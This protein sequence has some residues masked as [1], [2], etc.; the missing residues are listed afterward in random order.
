M[1][2]KVKV[3]VEVSLQPGDVQAVM[4]WVEGYKVILR[5][6]EV[7]DGDFKLR[8]DLFHLL[9]VLHIPVEL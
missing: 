7:V 5:S 6:P 1:K 4:I 9:I 3:K 8:S 2:I